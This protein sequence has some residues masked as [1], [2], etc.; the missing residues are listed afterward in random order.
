MKS[1]A[2]IQETYVINL[3]DRTDRRDFM[4]EALHAFG[5]KYTLVEAVKTDSFHGLL[6]TMKKLF[7][8]ALQKGQDNVLVLEDDAAFLVP[9]V[10]FLDSVLPQLPEHYHCFYLGINLVSPPKRIT[11][12]IL[13]VHRAYATHAIIY[14]R[15]AMEIIL[16]LLSE[17]V[18][19]YDIILMNNLQGMGLCYAT[20]PVIATQLPGYSDIEKKFMDWGALM[21]QT[22]AQYTKNLQPPPPPQDNKPPCWD[23]HRVGL[24]MPTELNIELDGAVCNCGKFRYVA[25]L[26]NCQYRPKEKL[27]KTYP[28]E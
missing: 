9:P 27:L 7:T 12:N 23:A 2:D 8:Q 6:E 11:E 13:H 17:H 24:I 15:E 5:I 25:E 21:T 10:P 14:S 22:F 18:T 28:N 4:D 16:Q 1:F 19:A 26:C 3:A 20:Y